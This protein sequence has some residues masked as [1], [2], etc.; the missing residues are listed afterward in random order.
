M[1]ILFASS[2]VQPLIKTGGLA[3]VCGALPVAIRAMGH[4]I[5]IVMPAYGAVTKLIG[6]GHCL[7]E[8]AL[9]GIPGVCRLL[10]TQLP[11]TDVDV[12]LVEYDPAFARLGN[13]YSTADGRPWRDNAERFALFGRV[14]S[15]IA[16]N[17]AGLNWSPD[18][19]HCNDWQ[20]GL[21]PA[22]LSLE[23]PRPTT[24]FTIHNLAYQGLFPAHVF[25]E[26]GLP[27]KLWSS[28]GL[29]FYGQL[30]FIKGGLAYA[31]RINTVSPTYM[32]E[33]KTTEFG[34]GL[35]GLLR[36]RAAVCS[37]I[38]NGIDTT[39]WN[40]ETDALITKT[41]AADNVAQH[42]I[43][44]KAAVQS[45][46]GIRQDRST[47]LL[48]FIGRLVEQKGID[49][50]IDLALRDPADGGLPAGVQLVVLGSGEKTVELHLRRLAQ[51]K[52]DRIGVY[53]GYNE[54][55]AHQ[56]EAG[57]DAFLMPSRFEPCG[58]NQLYSQR[59]GS[60]PIVHGVGGL[61]D[62]VVHADRVSLKN[63][64]ATGIVLPRLDAKSLLAAIVQVQALFAKP[65]L[66]N[67]LVRTAMR[68][69]FDWKQSAARYV[70][71]YGQVQGIKVKG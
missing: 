66:W 44:N 9:P 10:Y 36:H 11:D 34:Y 60:I 40:P 2:E 47:L 8:V 64:T 1:K 42:K 57:I 31:D 61:A 49:I 3:D 63:E 51:K 62:T 50:V 29:E 15:Q 5:R 69:N 52:P 41:Y 19:L 45:F 71:L 30:C 55:L 24:L 22:L 18:I 38:V 12:I 7:A 16:L 35:E 58:L 59:Y 13:P 43:A 21:A 56:I 39:V 48:G 4:D 54:A 23:N 53:I 68:Q 32:E 25:Q 27:T 70:E 28:E 17:R 46:F 33:I 37:G 67:K 20:T 14:I 26:L 65:S 6:E